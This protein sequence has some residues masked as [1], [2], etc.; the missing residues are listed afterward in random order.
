MKI[1]KVFDNGGATF[2]RHTII[3]EGRSDALGL[4]DNCNSPQGFSQFGVVIEGRH[5]G[6]QIQFA[7]LPE[8]VRLHIYERIT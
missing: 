5:L 6:R 1:S 7:D 2:D 8:N 4:S 3:F